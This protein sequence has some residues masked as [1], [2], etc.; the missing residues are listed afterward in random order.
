MRAMIKRRDPKLFGKKPDSFITCKLPP[1]LY[2][3]LKGI[4]GK[5]DDEYH[6]RKMPVRFNPSLR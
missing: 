4:E 6:T 1:Y 2:I 3:T 5:V